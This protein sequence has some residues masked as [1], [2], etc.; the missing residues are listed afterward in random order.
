[1]GSAAVDQNPAPAVECTCDG[2]GAVVITSCTIN[3]V[4]VGEEDVGVALQG[5]QAVNAAPPSKHDEQSPAECD[6]DGADVITRV[7]SCT[8]DVVLVGE[9]DVG[10]ALQGEQAVSPAKNSTEGTQRQEEGRVQPART[11]S[12]RAEMA[13]RIGTM[14]PGEGAGRSTPLGKDI[15]L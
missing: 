5:E 15:R 11:L 1:M 6:V 8:I 14:S 9:E 2:D 13:N 10:V 4:L 3:V 7:T 12:A